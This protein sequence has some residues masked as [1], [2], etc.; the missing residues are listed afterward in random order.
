MPGRARIGSNACSRP[1]PPTRFRFA[2]A[3]D[4]GLY[5]EALAL[6]CRTPCDPKTLTRAARDYAVRQP[7]FAREAGLHA[8]HWL[9][10][11]YGYEITSADVWAAYTST[12]A[13]AE[14]HGAVAAARARVREFVAAEAT[15]DRFVSRVLGAE[16]AR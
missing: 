11:G 16:L 9:V 2:A 4:A 12:L 8:L 5:A 1:T 7:A 6:A 14:R 3:K 10:Q 13:A 15:A